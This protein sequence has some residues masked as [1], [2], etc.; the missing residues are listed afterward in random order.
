MKRLVID[1]SVIID[2]LRRPDKANSLL[3]KV[4][5]E[6]LYISI[7]THTELYAG[8]SVWEDNNAKEAVQKVLEGMS[9]VP[10][11]E[12]ISQEAGHIRSY[13]NTSLIDAIVAATSVALEM[14]L[15]T[16]NTKDFEKAESIKLFEYSY[17]I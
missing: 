15:V 16:F 14:E 3:Y 5:E 6:E 2:F 9:L 11:D 12:L 10:L 8:K 1:T 13:T 7:I 4:A 17:L